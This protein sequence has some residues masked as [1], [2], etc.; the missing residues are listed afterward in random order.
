MPRRYE[1]TGRSRAMERTRDAI[2]DAA[3]E[4]FAPA[5]YDDVTLADVAR[6]AGVSQQTVVNH[7]GSKVGLYL[8][9]LTERVGP[10]I[11][12]ARSRAVP[13][14]VGSVVGVVVE[15]YEETGDG[16]ARLIAT[17]ERLPDLAGAVAAGRAAHRAF[18]E[19]AFAPQLARR[20]GAA[21]ERVLVR[22]A[23]VL[24]VTVWKRLRRD[25]GLSADETAG[26]LR[27]LVEG[28]LAG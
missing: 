12:S 28:V 21:R 15:D 10:G 8:A 20:R 1:M 16:T 7:F 4:L 6:A 26:H 3:V 5:W 25:E 14:D 18:V 11:D 13:G 2:L 9:G 24:D 23:T 17:A 19:T 22:L 27:A